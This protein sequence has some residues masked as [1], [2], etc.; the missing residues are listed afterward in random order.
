MFFRRL[1]TFFMQIKQESLNDVIVLCWIYLLVPFL[2][3]GEISTEAKVQFD[4]S[5]LFIQIKCIMHFLYPDW[6][7]TNSWE[8][9]RYRSNYAEDVQPIWYNEQRLLSRKV[10]SFSVLSF[11]HSLSS[12]LSNS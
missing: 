3:N 12:S 8:A 1:L 10:L 9:F 7:G 2:P 5:S 6:D 11:Y 4:Y